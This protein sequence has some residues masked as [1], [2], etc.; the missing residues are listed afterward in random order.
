[1]NSAETKNAIDDQPGIELE[2]TPLINA[3]VL[4]INPNTVPS[5]D[6][7][8]THLRGAPEVA[9]IDLNP[10]LA[11]CENPY[12]ENPFFRD[13]RSYSSEVDLKPSAG[14]RIL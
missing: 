7:T 9:S 8:E 3:I 4:T 13:F 5:T 10:R 12:F 2:I 1:V 11:S 6:N 14:I